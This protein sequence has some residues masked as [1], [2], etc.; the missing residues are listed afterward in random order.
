M[1]TQLVAS[2]ILMVGLASCTERQTVLVKNDEIVQ[3]QSVDPTSGPA[4]GGTTIT[5]LGSGFGADATVQVGGSPATNLGVVSASE[6]TCTVPAGTVGFAGVTVA[7][8]NGG[9]GSVPNAFRFLAKTSVTGVAPAI[10]AD[11]GGQSVTIS[12][13]GFQ[14][15]VAIAFGTTPATSIRIASTTEVTCVVPAGV[16]GRV[17]VRIT[18]PDGTSA[19]MRGAYEYG[20]PPLVTTLAP[21]SG[22]VGGGTLIGVYGSRFATG[23]TV[24][25]GGVPATNVTVVSDTVIHCNTP[26]GSA[27]ACDVTVTNTDTLTGSSRSG[28][29][30]VQL[31]GV[32]PDVTVCSPDVVCGGETV[33]VFGRDFSLT[34][35]TRLWFGPNEAASLTVLTTSQ[36]RAVVPNGSG[37]VNVAVV[38]YDGTSG[39]LANGLTYDEVPP[40]FSGIVS[41]YA[42][43]DRAAE[44]RW[45]PGADTK[46]P[47]NTLRYAVY[48]SEIAGGQDFSRPVIVADPG[49]TIVVD[50]G[51]R[52]NTTYH[53]VVRCRDECGNE[54]SN[55]VEQTVVT[56]VA[57]G[58]PYWTGVAALPGPA[59]RH[60]HI[61]VPLHSGKLLVAAGTI[62]TPRSDAYLYD[63]V[64]GSWTAT[65]N[66]LAT[67]RTGAG[68]ALL[69]NATVI[70]IG[71]HDSSAPLASCEFYVPTSNQWIA[72]PA[73]S[74]ARGAASV[75]VLDDSSV[76][77]AGGQGATGVLASVELA[78]WGF[79]LSP[80]RATGTMQTAR[81]EHVAVRLSDG[82]VLVAGGTDGTRAL[83]SCEVFDPNSETWSTTGSLGHARVGA[84]MSML[85]D[86]RVIIAGG[87]SSSVAE[88]YE[89]KTGTWSDASAGT[90]PGHSRHAAGLLP[91]GRLLVAG[92]VTSP[93]SSTELFDP[94]SNRWSAGAA[95]VVQRSHADLRLLWNG[96]PM[97]SGGLDPAGTDA[98]AQVYK[99]A[100]GASNSPPVMTHKRR[101]H[102][103]SLM[104]DGRV[105]VVGGRDDQGSLPSTPESWDPELRSNWSGGVSGLDRERHCANLVEIRQFGA[106]G[107][108]LL[109]S[110]GRT[111]TQVLGT[112]RLLLRSGALS[113]WIGTITPRHSH[114]ATIRDDG[115]V[116]IAGGDPTLNSR[117]ATGVT[118]LFNPANRTFFT[119]GGSSLIARAE[120]RAVQLQTGFVLVAGGRGAGS[121]LITAAQ[122]HAGSGAWITSGTMTQGRRLHTLTVLPDG[123]VL[124]AG[125]HS[126]ATTAL[127]TNACEIFDPSN[128][129]WTAA[130]A[131]N[132]AR[133]EHTAVLLATGRI[134]VFGGVTTGGTETAAVEVYEPDTRSWRTMGDL[135]AAMANHAAVLLPS[136]RVLLTGHRVLEWDE[137]LGHST[138][139]APAI[140]MISRS[141]NFPVPVGPSGFLVD[142]LRLNGFYEA[143]SGRAGA[144]SKA[145]VITIYGP[146]GGGAESLRMVRVSNVAAD[147]TS[148]GAN[149]SPLPRGY[150]L[151]RAIANGMPGPGRIVHRQ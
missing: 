56:P 113:S 107:P 110:G 12:G 121:S 149:F 61:A 57:S 50:G 131:M 97:I 118:Q 90:L 123:C 4:A 34:G 137:G 39:V 125:G 23:A 38:R 116:V 124:A 43:S 6:I 35:R 103:S 117:G 99:H 105:M 72:A 25:V 80:W 144:S 81:A 108:H 85:R 11:T 93:A 18:N 100:F 30:Y 47:P 28:Y 140:T 14:L 17:D 54:E 102:T 66:T 55:I 111:A 36:I 138:A 119:V 15:G 51:L 78:P 41:T 58:I 16:P 109:I 133:A 91:D 60:A 86:G 120:H 89:P 150:F 79:I 96:D 68:A 142:G 21:P 2:S 87:A 112:A 1:R 69:S 20:Q 129:T 147:G 135:P 44:L 134:A 42:V 115:M 143:S 7:H 141:S 94:S 22:E 26:A 104:E 146:L 74:T 29:S 53:Y 8:A 71:G 101:Y 59:P 84:S 48:R 13:S 148:V 63:P 10:G 77:V 98:R 106:A 82:R 151:V 31:S 88:I 130:A 49:S 73:L 76:L 95:L 64:T 70:A 5:I 114:T 65:A 128:N 45:N 33:F 83:R 132:T 52:A 19:E 24:T 122:R 37:T 46:S 126:S 136:G 145:A 139:W 62:A 40:A 127:P 75:T 3:I 67:A 92:N 32:S 9:K 27:G